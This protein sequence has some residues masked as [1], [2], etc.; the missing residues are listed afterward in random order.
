MSKSIHLGKGVLTVASIIGLSMGVAGCSGD[1][2]SVQLPPKPTD[3]GCQNW[4]F[5]SKRGVWQCQ[6]SS[7]GHS[8]AYYY[9]NR[10]YSTENDLSKSSS[11]QTYK[12][13]SSFA[14]EGG[15]HSASVS[16][17][18]IGGHASGGGE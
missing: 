16:E 1:E 9:G 11:Y 7:T 6:K 12:S 15:T 4:S 14:G 8:G 5:D 18:G 10:Y 2:N 3:K 17:G 13:S